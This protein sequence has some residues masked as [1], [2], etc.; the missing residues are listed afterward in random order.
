VFHV[1]LKSGRTQLKV[2]LPRRDSQGAI[3][4][5]DTGKRAQDTV[6]IKVD[7]LTVK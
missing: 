1:A 3:Y 7:N 2:E 6:F 4:K 5:I